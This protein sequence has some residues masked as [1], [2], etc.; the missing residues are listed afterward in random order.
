MLE[1]EKLLVGVAVQ[2]QVRWSAH[3]AVLALIV[4]L[5]VMVVV[6]LDCLVAVSSR[7]ERDGGAREKK[8]DANG[9]RDDE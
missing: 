2:E 5:V 8:A 7:G 9:N 6:G 1:P 3:E 4:L